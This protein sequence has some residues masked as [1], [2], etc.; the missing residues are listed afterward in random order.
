MCSVLTAQT[1]W[2]GESCE[3]ESRRIEQ[4]SGTLPNCRAYE[5]VTP[6]AKES[7]EPKAVVVGLGEPGL[8]SLE[9]MRASLTGDRMSWT[10]EYVL[11]GSESPGL[12]YLSMRG[13]GGWASE[14]VIPPQSVENGTNCPALVAMA[15]YSTDLLKGVLADGFGQ[16]GSFKGESLD[17][18]HDQPLLVPGEPQGFQDLFVRDNELRSYRLVNVTPPSAPEPK[19]ASSNKGE[20][21]PAAFQAG[22]NDLGDVVFEEEL[23]LTPEAGSGDELY[24]FGAGTVNLVTILPGGAA[25][26]GVLAGSTPNAGLDES[27]GEFVP[28]SIANFRHAVSGDGRR[29]F[30]EAEGNLYVRMNPE[31][32]HEKECSD[33]STACTLEI[34]ATQ[35]GSSSSGAGRFT[36]ASEDGSKVFFTDESRLTP[37]STAEAG[38]PDLYEYDLERPIG[39]R[40]VDLTDHAGEPADVLGVSGASEDGAYVYFVADAALTGEQPN[41]QAAKAQAGQP[42]LYV[43]HGGETTFVATLDPS[44]DS[45]DWLSSACVNYPLLGGSTARVPADGAFI[46][47]DS[48]GSLTG[49][50]NNG[51]TC[52]P[53]LVGGSSSV[54]GFAPGPCQ[55]IYL[56]DATANTLSCASCDPSG[57]T[58]VGP[59]VIRFP[60]PASQDAEMRNAYPQR[61]VSDSGE[62][63]FESADPLVPHASNGMLN[64]YAYEHGQQYLL[65]SGTSRTNS[66]FLDAS[67]DGG[68]AFFATAQPLLH[69]DGDSAYDIYDA[70]VNG[71]FPEPAGPPPQCQNEGC[72]APATVTSAFSTP[73]SVTFSGPGDVASPAPQVHTA[74]RTRHKVKRRHKPRKRTRKKRIGRRVRSSLVRRQG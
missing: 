23:P 62:V 58:P 59:A 72:R 29:V 41:S 39:G 70:R 19:P 31:Q 66:Y 40:L 5:L 12:D 38:R 45:C 27:T 2:A 11:P 34:D 24:E 36:V 60:G 67:P 44:N 63:F 52:V 48:D 43:L 16:P 71:G 68:N 74:T 35:G 8:R 14:N 54:E 6:P 7:D 50:D 1:A 53:E 22:S 73:S 49:Y 42:N 57:A 3:N 46:A 13:A 47:F 26:H 56:Y 15:A 30:F 20:Y 9:G 32:P 4:A 28:Y 65:S 55:E 18:G 69:S 64:V 21:F 51:P 33:P 17:C 10:S 25:V 61:N 37:G